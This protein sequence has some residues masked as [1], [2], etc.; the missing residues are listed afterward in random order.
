MENS[1]ALDRRKF[2]LGLTAGGAIIGAGV[3]TEKVVNA[4]KHK[5]KIWIDIREDVEKL[6]SQFGLQSREYAVVVNPEAQELYLV[7]DSKILQIYP[8]STSKNG[9]GTRVGSEKTPWGTHRIKEKI[10]EGAP[11]GAVFAGRQPTGEI[12]NIERKPIETGEDLI[13]TRIMWLEGEE[14]NINKGEG[15]DS[16]GRYIYIHGA[17]EEGLIGQP[18]SHGCIRMRN[19][20]VIELFN[21]VPAGTLVEIQPREYQKGR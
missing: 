3:I 15:V 6:E 7:R 2:L 13:T 11:E 21:R 20:D 1:P 18:A 14:E 19:K 8:V 17:Q 4:E 10:G 12:A 9:I 16:H 5:E